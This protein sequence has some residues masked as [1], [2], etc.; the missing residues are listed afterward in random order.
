V[1]T[2]RD[3]MWNHKIQGASFQRIDGG[4]PDPRWK[5]SPGVLWTALVPHDDTLQKVFEANHKPLWHV[6][7]GRSW[8]G[9]YPG[10]RACC[11]YS[12]GKLYHMNAH[13]RVVCLD[14][15]TGKE[16]WTVSNGRTS[17]GR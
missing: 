14:A 4:K 10:S 15:D 12:E 13:G 9:S 6:K 5:E 1:A 17:L 8:T 2:N 3:F 7:N 16:R 11:A